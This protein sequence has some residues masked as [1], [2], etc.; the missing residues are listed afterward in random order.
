MNSPYVRNRIRSF[1]NKCGV[2]VEGRGKPVQI[3][4]AIL[5]SVRWGECHLE[6][7]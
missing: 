7:M 5:S 6:W 4:Q 2:G 1:L 3:H